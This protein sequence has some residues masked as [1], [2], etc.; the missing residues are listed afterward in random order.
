[1][2]FNGLPLPTDHT[3]ELRK[4]LVDQQPVICGCP[5]QGVETGSAL[6]A[7]V[8]GM[9]ALMVPLVARARVLG[10]ALV[11]AGD[12]LGHF[13]EDQIRLAQGVADSA[14]LTIENASLYAKSQGLAIAE[15]RGRLAQEIHDGLAQGLTAISLQLDLADA[16]LPAK[17]EKAAE[18]VRRALDLTRANLEEA[19]RS[20]L[21]LRAAR[22]QEVALPDALRRLV[23]QFVDDSGIETEFGADSIGGRLSARVEMGLLRIAEE[24]LDNIRRHAAAQQVRLSLQTEADQVTLTIE[25]DGVGFDPQIAARASQ[26]GVGFGLVG[27]RERARLLKGSLSIQSSQGTGTKLTVTVPFEAR[28]ARRGKKSRG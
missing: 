27:V 6:R 12:E 2:P 23:Q 7:I 8:G 21:D 4:M 1:L 22:L 9:P 28:Q 3:P 24:A 16:Y 26:Q 18:K 17:P 25:D 13:S 5:H 15:E 14:A 11:S 19:R 10:M 20:V